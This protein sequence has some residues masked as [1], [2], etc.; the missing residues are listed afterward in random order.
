MW[1]TKLL[2]GIKRKQIILITRQSGW[3]LFLE[4]EIEGDDED[5]GDEV[6]KMSL[7]RIKITLVYHSQDCTIKDENEKRNKNKLYWT[8]QSPEN[9]KLI[10]ICITKISFR[11]F[12]LINQLKKQVKSFSSR[13]GRKKEWIEIEKKGEW[14]INDWFVQ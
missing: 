8:T 1:T 12:A 14:N 10:W 2:S 11:W 13:V 4:R 5:D 6:N 9:E 7:H 3:I